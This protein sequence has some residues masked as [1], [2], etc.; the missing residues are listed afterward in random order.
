VA[1]VYQ[2]FQS[3]RFS[4]LFDF[5]VSEN[6]FPEMPYSDKSEKSFD[7][8]SFAPNAPIGSGDAFFLGVDF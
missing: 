7:Q 1:S 4:Q 5:E 8:D 3:K 2:W 6:V